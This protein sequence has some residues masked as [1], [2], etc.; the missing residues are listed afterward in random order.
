MPRSAKQPRRAHL[1]PKPVAATTTG[2]HGKT[3]SDGPPHLDFVNRNNGA[4]PETI[5]EGDLETLNLGLGFFFALMREAKRLY[6]EEGDGGRAAAFSSRISP[7]PKLSCARRILI[8]D[9][10]PGL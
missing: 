2:T 5:A 10:P 9:L 6:D 7:S 3:Q 1:N 8:T 4:L